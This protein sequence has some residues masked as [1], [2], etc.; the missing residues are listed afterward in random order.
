MFTI[1]KVSQPLS[2]Q[3]DQGR[4]LV[5]PPELPHIA[6]QIESGPQV[7]ISD[8]IFKV[9]SVIAQISSQNVKHIFILCDAM[10]SPWSMHIYFDGNLN[11]VF[12]IWPEGIYSLPV[13]HSYRNAGGMP[14]STCLVCNLVYAADLKEP[15]S[16]SRK[17]AFQLHP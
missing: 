1:L 5:S 9:G 14:K 15:V 13:Y 16:L 7:P 6:L 8:I 12:P 11:F 3:V 2:L 10:Q 4:F 17:P